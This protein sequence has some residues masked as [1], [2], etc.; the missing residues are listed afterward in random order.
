[1]NAATWLWSW[2]RQASTASKA[3]ALETV[4]PQLPHAP[5]TPQASHHTQIQVLLVTYYLSRPGHDPLGHSLTDCDEWFNSNVITITLIST[6]TTIS[7]I[8]AI[9]IMNTITT[10][11]TDISPKSPTL[12]SLP[13]QNYHPHNCPHPYPPN[14]FYSQKPCLPTTFPLPD[15]GLC[16]AHYVSGF[17]TS[18]VDHN[19]DGSSQYGIFQLNSAWWCDNGVTPTKNL[20]H[21]ECHGEA[22]MGIPW[23][24]DWPNTQRAKLSEP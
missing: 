11:I 23:S 20:C 18:V 16:M 14:L 17:D 19:V 22:A 13:N 4:R 9:T 15:S 3:T 2:R 8:T 6:I 1:M 12:T 7:V 5:P 10:A 21:M 24:P